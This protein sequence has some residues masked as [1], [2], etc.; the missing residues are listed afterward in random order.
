MRRAVR[1]I[2]LRGD[3]L[4]VMHRNKFGKEYE[5]L[6]GGAIEIGE[7]PEAALVRELAEETSVAI[8]NPRLVMVE[9]AGP[10]YGTQY[11]YLCTYVS[12]EPALHPDSEES[13]IHAMGKNLYQPQWLPVASLPN[14]PF[15]SE[16]LKVA[17]LD[18]IKAGF[19]EKP[20]QI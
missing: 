13:L 16:R 18:G 19:P 14:A 12:G 17:I 3:D 20:Q 2:I 1:A 8:S 4:L 11:V 10:M 6:P 15:V 9:D 5:T 7:E